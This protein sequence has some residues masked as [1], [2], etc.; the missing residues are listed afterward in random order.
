MG[1]FFD[2]F[3]DFFLGFFAGFNQVTYEYARDNYDE[4]SRLL[5]FITVIVVFLICIIV[6]RQLRKNVT[7][8]IERLAN[9]MQEVSRGN[10]SIRIPVESGFELNQMES[11]FNKMADELSRSKN[12]KEMQ[13]QRNRM[14]YAGIAHDLKTPMTM[15][16]GYA[17]AVKDN[18]EISADDRN[19]YLEIIVKQT[20]SVNQ[21]LDSMLAY[22][23][24]NSEDYKIKKEKND[25]AECLRICV[26]DCYSLIEEKQM[27]VNLEIPDNE[28][29][30]E[31]DPIEMKRVFNNL[32]SNMIKHNPKN[33]SCIIRLQE[34]SGS[35][36]DREKR[37]EI[38]IADNGPKID[39]D[40]QAN[41]FDS[42]VVGDISR[43][44]K[45][46]SG[47]GLS[48]SKKIIERHGGKIYYVNEWQ[49]EYKGFVIEM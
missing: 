22:S 3:A 34:I 21:L 24:L 40:L 2:T 39:E 20:E 35:K 1:I 18:S 36:D 14:L 8:P 15:I 11:A 23:K 12:I 10:L 41:L 42:F 28:I 26:T 38:V 31:F 32:L 9:G 46:G 37:V 43:N 44:T 16:I 4:L 29:E 45:N 33:T 5:S 13:E 6:Y 47:L 19:R 48:V 30:V 17:K 49:T 25:I 27:T 7:L